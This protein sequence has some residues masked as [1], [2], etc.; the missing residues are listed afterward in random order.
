MRTH[1]TEGSLPRT[2]TPVRPVAPVVPA[3]PARTWGSFDEFY[4]NEWTAVAALAHTLCGSHGTAEELA[5]DAFVAVY[6]NWDRV[7]A[8]DRPDAWVRR[9]VANSA[10]SE[11]RRRAAD[12]RARSRLRS[13]RPA[14]PARTQLAADH[15]HFWA[16]VRRLP[17]R[18]AQAVALH[19]LED[20]SVADIARI[21]DCAEGTV[22]VHL[23]RGR[24]ALAE[25]L[26]AHEEDAR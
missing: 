24:T 10:T 18:Q 16:A 3:A 7:S 4:R 9:V 17:P 14:D 5:Q 22:K 21:L 2:V 26:A 20:R 23:H 11:L 19:Y 6:R 12:L 15:D 25:R 1:R 13:V 8:M